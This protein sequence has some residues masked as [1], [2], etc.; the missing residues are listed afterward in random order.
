MSPDLLGGDHV[1][2]VGFREVSLEDSVTSHFT[3]V[4]PCLWMAKKGFGEEQDERLAEVTTDLTAENMEVV[5]GCAI[6]KVKNISQSISQSVEPS[7]AEHNSRRVDDLHI[8]ILMLTIELVLRR[9]DMR[10]IIAQL[11]KPFQ[12]SR[13]ML[14][15]LSIIPMRQVDNQPRTLQPFPLARRK[16]LIDDALRII[17][18]VPELRLPDDQTRRGYERI[19]KFESQDS[20][21]G[22]RRIARGECCLVLSEILEW[23]ILCLGVLVV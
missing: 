18:E 17:R 21:F 12:P 13:T 11:Q 15:T 2:R 8:T 7:E 16:E 20:E 5:G 4:G 9:V 6:G 19:P 3:E 14:G 22:E 10:M 1:L 23:G